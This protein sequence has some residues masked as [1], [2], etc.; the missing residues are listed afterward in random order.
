MPVQFEMIETG[1]P[2][3]FR[4]LDVRE[5]IRELGVKHPDWSVFR[6]IG[7]L[8]KLRHHPAHGFYPVNYESGLLLYALVTCFR[9]RQVLEIGTGRGFASIC[10]A[11]ALIDQ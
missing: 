5:K 9:P 11:R 4:T 2:A 8:T 6:R 1:S 10:M 7:D 3:R